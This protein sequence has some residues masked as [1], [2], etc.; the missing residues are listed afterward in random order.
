MAASLPREGQGDSRLPA[1]R[2]YQRDCSDPS[3]VAG[4]CSKWCSVCLQIPALAPRDMTQGACVSDDMCEGDTNTSWGRKISMAWNCHDR[5]TSRKKNKKLFLGFAI[6]FQR[7]ISVS[8]WKKRTL[9]IPNRGPDRG[10]I[11]DTGMWLLCLIINIYDNMI[12][13]TTSPTF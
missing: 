9:T 8:H 1:S 5:K 7:L 3:T 10:W 6:Y 4:G 11:L 2:H 13:T 12:R